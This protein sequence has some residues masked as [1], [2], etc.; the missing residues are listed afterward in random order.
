MNSCLSF[1]FTAFSMIDIANFEMDN[2]NNNN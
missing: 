1:N 2:N